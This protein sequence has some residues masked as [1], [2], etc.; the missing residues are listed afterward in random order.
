MNT[1][2]SSFYDVAIVGAGPVG[3][4]C[5]LA[6]AQRGARVALLEANTKATKRMAGEWLHPPAVRILKE[7]GVN[8]DEHA[9][10]TIGRGF[11][12][13]PEDNSDPIILPYSDDAYGLACEHSVIV[14]SLHEAVESQSGI[15]FISAA[16]VRKIEGKEVFFSHEGNM[17]SVSAERIVGADGRSSLVRRSLGIGI[18][19]S[20]MNCSRMVGVTV[21]NVDLPMETYGH[22]LSGG[23][24]P[25]FIY[26]LREDQIRVIV[27]IPP[28]YWNSSDRVG[29]L[30]EVSVQFLPE[31]LR[32]AFIE[33][34][35]EGEFHGAVNS[36]SPRVSYGRSDRVLIGD[37]AGYYHPLTAIGMTLGFGDA[38]AL[39]ESE[40]FT[41]FVVERFQAVRTPELLAMEIYEVFADQHVEVTS[42]RKALYH[43]WRVS[44]SFRS[45]T[46]RLLACEEIAISNMALA[47]SKVLFEAVGS[48]IPKS[49]NR[50]DWR[51]TF[52]I[53]HS[54][55]IRLWWLIRGIRLLEKVKNAQGKG[56]SQIWGP[57]ARALPHSVPLPSTEP[58]TARFKENSP[59]ETKQSIERGSKR[60]ID[61]QRVDGA[62]EG[63]MT[64]CP[65]LTAQYVLLHYIMGRKLSPERRRNILRS[66]EYT[67]LPNGTWGM[68]DHSPPHLFV[69]T[70]VYVAARLLNVER[71][72]P[73][74]THARQFLR[75]E[76]VV[77]IPSWGKFWLATLNLYQ[78]KGVNAV[79]P[80]L[81]SLP[82]WIPLHPSNWYCH[83][84][85]I[86][87]GVA[88]IYSRRFQVSVTPLIESLREELFPQGYDNIN[89]SK[90]RNRLRPDDLYAPPGFLLRV[91]YRLA[92]I[93]DKFHSKLF[94]SRCTKNLIQRIKWELQTTT[95]TSIS[96]VSGFLNI[97]SLWLYEPTNSDGQ[98]AFE[99]LDDWIWEDE[100]LGTRVT[101]ARSSSWDTGFALQAFSTIRELDGVPDALKRGV[102]FLR[103]QQI[104]TTFEGFEEFYRIDPKGGWCF[105]G[106]WH[107]WPVSDCTAEAVLGILTVDP[108]A[109]SN[110]QVEEAATFMLRRQNPDGGFGSYERRKSTFGLEWLN[111][112]EMFG[113][114]MTEVSYVE[115][116]ASCLAAFAACQIHFPKIKNQQIVSAVS[117]G[118]DWL[119][120]TQE[121]DGS[122]RGVWGIQYIYG[123]LFG[124]RGLIAAGAGPGDPA[125]RLACRWLL[126]HQREDGG[127]GEHNS[128]SL[129]G[130]YIQHVESQVIQTAWALM[131]LL[132]AENPN[133]NAITGGVR[134]LI[135]SQNEDG[136]WP[137]QDMVGVF[138]RTALLDYALYRQYF[139]LHA[140]GL[141]EQRRKERQNLVKSSSIQL[142]GSTT[143]EANS[144][145][146]HAIHSGNSITPSKQPVKQSKFA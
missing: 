3:S 24:G 90:A 135:E 21:K 89:F 36:M 43:R 46:M 40:R 146:S 80:E 86:Y 137:K 12:V 125:I 77:E 121:E 123:T 76:D 106:G 25:M 114:S 79:L 70:L 17:E 143:S 71:D 88:V 10:C 110:Q 49:F 101:G 6:H 66:F 141:Y 92:H 20:P 81:W 33:S 14:S 117:S 75:R 84:R 7:V 44:P 97:L 59:I 65:M 30:S 48:A 42:V 35:Q 15:D 29:Y 100:E 74:I 51:R 115:C 22:L 126:E 119:R 87:M 83:T 98:Q 69:T 118:D 122:W 140:L 130:Q 32:S 62:W 45:R 52:V 99:K 31:M 109:M 55:T 129:T 142:N 144:K 13:L 128:G 53:V 108:Q 8:L 145:L 68:H 26:R 124:I 28:H 58:H 37:A 63:E 2:S 41:D 116:T 111:P 91:G 112:A 9:H 4:V 18:K 47:G 131:A 94:R 85:L 19:S 127:W 103:E 78:W 39:A 72:A 23:P 16:R 5:A 61:L 50:L 132:E 105:P 27:D 107:G 73:L 1:S 138:F 57:F 95:H 64:W 136:T 104:R 67:R 113:D 56:F 34:L 82:R 102:N 134:F 139:P 54:L 38:L 60:L 96:P 11:V 133:W 120:R 93:F